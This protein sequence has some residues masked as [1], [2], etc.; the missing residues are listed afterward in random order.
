MIV[1]RIAENRFNF[2]YFLIKCICTCICNGF[3]KKGKR[4]GR[5]EKVF[6]FEFSGYLCEKSLF[7]TFELIGEKFEN[8]FLWLFKTFEFSGHFCKKSFFGVC[9]LGHSV[10]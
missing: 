2:I 6:L 1:I 10:F 8:S 3:N 5:D 7:L 4:N 9:D